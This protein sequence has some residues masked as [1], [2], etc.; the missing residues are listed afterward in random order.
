M[1]DFIKQ[2]LGLPV[3]DTDWMTFETWSHPPRMRRRVN[4]KWQIRA[5]TE[6]E[7]DTHQSDLAW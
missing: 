5:M 1:I 2:L 7:M 3:P 4:G 6:D